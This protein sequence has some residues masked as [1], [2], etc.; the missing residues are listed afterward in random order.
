MLCPFCMSL[1]RLPGTALCWFGPDHWCGPGP[2]QCFCCLAF[3]VSQVP[4]ESFMVSPCVE[5]S[6][7]LGQ[8]QV[9]LHQQIGRSVAGLLGWLVGC[10][11]GL[12]VCWFVGLVACLLAW[13]VGWLVRW[14]VSGLPARSLAGWLACL[15]AC[16]LAPL[17]GWLLGWLP[18]QASFFPKQCG[19]T[20]GS[21]GRC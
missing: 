14:L 16:L 21:Y 18:A 2:A 1:L 7:T 17:V 12:L 10:L 6:V 15:L 13:L 3:G 4:Q 8:N 9:P 20:R 11:L 5:Q 19:H